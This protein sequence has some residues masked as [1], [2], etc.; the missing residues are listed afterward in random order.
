MNDLNTETLQQVLQRLSQMIDSPKEPTLQAQEAFEAIAAILPEKLVDPGPELW[1]GAL[2]LADFPERLAAHE[3]IFQ[4]LKPV[5][6]PTITVTGV[7]Q[8]NLQPPPPPVF[9]AN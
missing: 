8:D 9:P 6:L 4:N 5:E 1:T 2:S 3:A 7:P